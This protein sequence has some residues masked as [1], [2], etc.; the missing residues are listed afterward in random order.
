MHHR[1][2]HV[3]AICNNNN[4]NIIIIII[5]ITFWCNVSSGLRMPNIIEIDSRL[6]ELF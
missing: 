2:E 3:C 6:T 4:N 5:I 1:P